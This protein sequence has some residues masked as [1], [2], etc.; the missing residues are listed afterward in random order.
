MDRSTF[1]RSVIKNEDKQA[2]DEYGK[3]QQPE[4]ISYQLSR[5]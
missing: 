2:I 1:A 4:Q 3:V 5:V